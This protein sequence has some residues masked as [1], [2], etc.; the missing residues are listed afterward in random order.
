MTED[1]GPNEDQL[2]QTRLFLEEICCELC[3]FRHVKENDVAPREVKI[4]REVYLDVPGSFADIRV[5]V[6][7]LAPYFVEI[8][9]G[10]PE[11]RLLAHLR[12]KYGAESRAAPDADRVVVLVRSADHTDWPD[13]EAK[14]RSALRPGL[15]LEVWD[16]SHLSR[17]IRDHFEVEI[18][19]ISGNDL[20]KVRQAIDVAKWR[21][22]FGDDFAGDALAAPLLWHFGFW[23]LRR[24]H[25][26]HGLRPDEVMQAGSYE[27]VAILIADLSSFSSYVRDTRD[28]ELVRHCLTSF[29]P[30]ARYA[31][32]NTGG[33]MYMFGS[34]EVIGLFGLPDRAGGYIDDALNC[35]RA[36]V[37]IGNSVS[38]HWQ[39]ELDRVQ[40]SGGVH[41]GLAIGDLNLVPLRPYAQDQI[42]FIGDALNMT[43]RL[44]IAA[45]P[46]E[47]VISNGLY[48]KL[49]ADVQRPF[50]ELEPVEAKNVGLI[51]C[52]KLPAG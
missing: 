51:Q 13:I 23:T 50:Q 49:D 6:P 15:A 36:L 8:K 32:L 27:A 21:H 52:W 10:Y 9:F 5:E 44:M 18:G 38:N 48:Q 31:I 25:E 35:A 20:L 7:R 39:R 17:L 40:A 24:L 30:K 42:G 29:Y 45:G 19:A 14:L 46:S 16:E 26:E 37:D 28:D 41:I 4:T 33:M 43:S 11:E 47:I 2:Q 34:D 22:G 1:L 12:R 3:R